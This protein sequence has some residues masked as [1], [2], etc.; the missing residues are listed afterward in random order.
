MRRSAA[1]LVAT[2]AAL[3]TAAAPATAEPASADG[4]LVVRTDVSL[5]KSHRNVRPY[6]TKGARPTSQAAEAEAE[7]VGHRFIPT[8]PRRV[9]DTR[10]GLGRNGV[11]GPVG[12]G[13]QIEVPLVGY[14]ENVSAVVLNVTGTSPTANTYVTVWEGGPIARPQVSTLNLVPGDTR[15]NSVTT[16]VSLDHT[17]NLYNNAGSTDLIADVAGYYVYDAPTPGTGFATPGRYFATGPSRAYDSRNT[18]GAFYAGETRSIDFSS[19][20]VPAGATAV[21]LNITGVDATAGTYVTAW[22]SGATRPN[23]SSLNVTPGGATPNGVTVALGS[24]RKVN[25]YNNAG[26]VNLIVDITGYY[27]PTEVGGADFFPTDPGRAYDTREPGAS[28]AIP[29]YTSLTLFFGDAGLFPGDSL[30]VNLTGTEPT[31][32]TYITPFPSGE[33]RPG[34]SALNLA[35]GQTAPNMATVR[36]GSYYD[37]GSGVSYPAQ[38]YYNNAGFTHLVIDV[39]G[40]FA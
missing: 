32:N 24:D 19:F 30:L 37:E 20:G 5:D 23:A 40:V 17:V 6:G 25:V 22:P 7:W 11:A 12:H 8:A 27:L 15:A 34:T 2:A 14:P 33:A 4:D 36:L 28:G 18:G 31:D 26:F 21:A 13:G 10:S 35:P 9:L 1:L 38:D 3:A 39:F 16:W 29:P